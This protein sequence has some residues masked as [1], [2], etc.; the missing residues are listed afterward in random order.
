[1]HESSSPGAPTGRGTQEPSFIPAL[2]FEALTPAYDAIV[3]LTTRERVVK[4]ALLDAARLGPAVRL[5]DVGCGTGT[6]AIAAKRRYPHLEVV[7]ID[8][9]PSVLTRARDKARR[10]QVD[11]TFV[12]GSATRLPFPDRAFDR[13]TSSL[14]FHHLTTAQKRTAGA[15]ARR[16]LAAEGELHVADWVQAANP[17]MR[18]L[19]WSV[20]LLDGV[21]T[22]RDHAQGRLAELLT[23]GGLAEVVIHRRFATPAGSLGLLSARPARPTVRVAS[24]PPS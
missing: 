16:V 15:E 1:M 5:L 8:P 3:R 18:A 6:F 24:A 23:S 10:E 22:T 14:M 12:A 11:V 7:G 2:R 9:D 13:M 21:E 20:Q 17:L 4:R 19:F